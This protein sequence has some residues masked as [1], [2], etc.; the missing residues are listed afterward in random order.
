MFVTMPTYSCLVVAALMLAI[1]TPTA[2]HHDNITNITYRTFPIPFLPTIV[3]L[4]RI[5]T[6]YRE[7]RNSEHRPTRSCRAGAI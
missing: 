2:P 5:Y 7:T 1:Y 6:P 3:G 4:R